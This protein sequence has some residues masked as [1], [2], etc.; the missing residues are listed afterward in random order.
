MLCVFVVLVYRVVLVD[1]CSVL[2][3]CWFVLYVVGCVCSVVCLYCLS[4]LLVSFFVG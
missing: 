3:V 4:G 2:I 1:S